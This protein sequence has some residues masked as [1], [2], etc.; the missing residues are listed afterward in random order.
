[1]MHKVNEISLFHE[2]LVV[3]PLLDGW[4]I[5][6]KYKVTTKDQQ[7]YVVRFSPI[8]MYLQKKMEFNS[9]LEACNYT[10]QIPRP[11]EVGKIERFQ[12]CYIIYQYIEGIEA[13]KLIAELSYDKQFDLGVQAGVIL[14]Q[15]HRIKAPVEESAYE[16]MRLKIEKKKRLYQQ[17]NL[18]EPYHQLIVDYLD[19]H[20]PL[21][22]NQPTNFCHG[23]FHIGNM[24]IGED[25]MLYVIDFNRSNIE[26]PYQDFNRMITFGVKFSIAF[27]RGQL[28]GYFE[29]TTIDDR[30]FSIMLFYVCMDI[31]FGLLW[32]KQFGQD[33]IAMHVELTAQ[34]MRDFD[35]LRRYTPIWWKG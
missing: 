21:L 2:A 1:M 7:K 4:S 5:D 9:V 19:T 25:G 27:V 20:L 10:N 35:E 16:Q 31:G 14:R 32:A 33:E 34:I 18:E 11:I 8:S 30:I 23:D 12:V 3:E 6:E 24:I 17:E 26:D 28:K 22:K 15:L 29:E 13:I